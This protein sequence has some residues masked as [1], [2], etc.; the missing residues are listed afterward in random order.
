MSLFIEGITSFIQS[1]GLAKLFA[2]TA[3][4]PLAFAGVDF[5]TIIMLAFSCFL[6][7]LAIGK[8]F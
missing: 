3:E 2:A 8:E 4:T 6:I 1:T 7:Y 5:G